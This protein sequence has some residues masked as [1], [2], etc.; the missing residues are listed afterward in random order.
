[1]SVEKEMKKDL[2][3]INLEEDVIKVIQLL[4]QKDD[5]LP[6]KTDIDNPLLMTTIDILCENLENKKN[7]KD[8]LIFPSSVATLNGFRNWYRINMVSHKRKGRSEI[9]EALRTLR[10]YTASKLNRWLGKENES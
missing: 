10:E 2:I 9:I 7:S 1:M 5:H 3:D 8:E 6:L 4:A